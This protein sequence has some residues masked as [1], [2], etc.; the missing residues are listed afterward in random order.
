MICTVV[1]AR[2]NFIKMAPIIHELRR[3]AVPQFFVHTGQH[4]D[5]SMSDVFF[6]QLMM[7]V[8]D[9]YLGV[10]SGG[11]ADQTARIM[12]AFDAVCQQ[13][14]FSLVVVAGDVNSTLACALVAA[15]R[16]IPVAHV[17]AGLRSFDR[18]MPEEINRV[19]TDHIS[20]LFFTT[21]PSGGDNLL[22]EGIDPTKIHFVGNSMIDSLYKHLDHALAL[23][24]WS[25]YALTPGEYGVVTLHRPSNVDHPAVVEA[26]VAALAQVAQ[27]LPLIFP[28]H[29][30]TLARSESL[31]RGIP[32]LQIVEPLGYLEFL[33]LMARAKLAIT[34][35]GG[36]Q[37][38]TAALGVPCF[39]VRDNTERP[40][41]LTRGSNQLVQ[42]AGIP[43]AVAGLKSAADGTRP[44]APELW[45]GHAAERIVD[46]LA[47]GYA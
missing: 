4:Y 31:W 44:P 10:G 42:P 19:L 47:A 21:E 45:D 9:A 8:P 33:G 39:T 28:I 7:P 41:T 14:S 17:E 38:E 6:S 1:G 3:R 29:P 43:A 2:P 15:K 30:R 32:N 24:P 26:L 27:T 40:V 12:T 23:A 5:P 37:E 16:M 20:D 18:S 35:S 22:R 13:Q 36:I 46:I 25:P 34:D 11:H